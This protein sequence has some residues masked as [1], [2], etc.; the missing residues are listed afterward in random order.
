MT[1]AIKEYSA[2][3]AALAELAQKYKG[4][5]FDVTAPEGM[6]AAR[7]G[8]SELRTFRTSL[9]KV[10]VQLKEDVLVRGRLIDGEA[11]RIT[12]ELESLETPIDEQIKKEEQRIEDIRTAKARE[13]MERIAAQ[14]KA[15]RDAEQARIVA[16][17]AEIAMRQAEL[18]RAERERRLAD[19]DARRRIEDEQRAAHE[20]IEAEERAARKR[21]QDEE[22][23][24]HATMRAAEEEARKAREAEEARIAQQRREEEDR[25]AAERAKLEKERRA[26]EDAQRK[27]REAEEARQREARR[28]DNQK[29]DGRAMLASFRE[30]FGKVEEFAPVVAAIDKYLKGRK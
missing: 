19:E 27:E 13:E 1:T 7:K 28:I 20:K 14:E 10:R 11:K 30:Q 23:R 2:T 26:V 22:D 8:R 16:E 5:L 21:M 25:L 6:G 17:R 12:A 3:E 24:R 29:L 15:A 18:D 4:V 9:E